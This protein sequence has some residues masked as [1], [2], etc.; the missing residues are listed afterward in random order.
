MNETRD[1]RGR[2]ALL[3]RRAAWINAA[4][5]VGTATLMGCDRGADAR[6]AAAARPAPPAPVRVARVERTDFPVTVSAIGWV[7]ALATVVV[8]PQVDG[9][10]RDVHFAEGEELTE[11]QL[12]FSID[13]R[14]FETALQL[15]EA[16]RERDDAIAANAERE[17]QRVEGLFERGQASDR[18]RSESRYDADAKHAQV[19]ADEADIAR[20]RLNLEY[21]SIRAPLAG[22]AGSYLVDRGNVVKANETELVTINQHAPIHVTFSLPEQYLGL[23]RESMQ[24]GPVAVAAV[25]DDSAEPE[26]GV[27]AF[28]DNAV[29]RATGMVRLKATFANPQRRLW[30]GRFVQVSLAARVIRDAAVVPA[31]AVQTGQQGQYVYRVLPDETVALTAVRAGVTIGGCTV[32]EEGLTGDEAVVT[33]G[34]LRLTPGAKVRTNDAPALPAAT[35]D[36]AAPTTDEPAAPHAPAAGVGRDAAGGGT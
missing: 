29:D 2:A 20:A 28:V 9:Q 23:I 5:L 18:E 27:L 15:A 7:E 31:A 16:M 1:A 24:A 33:D 22:R 14:P 6:G 32:I 36:A 12:L 8:K 13:P 19:R 4:L 3:A 21:C 34:H 17:A 30:P 11:G 25:V 35:D 10:L 26:S